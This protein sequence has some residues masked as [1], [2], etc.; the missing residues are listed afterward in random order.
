MG[1]ISKRAP[2][3]RR[4]ARAW[5]GAVIGSVLVAGILA[6]GADRWFYAVILYSVMIGFAG[7]VF[8]WVVV[9]EYSNDLQGSRL[10]LVAGVAASLVIFVL[11]QYFR[12]RLAVIDL[13]VRPGW[14]EY[15][16]DSARNTTLS[17]RIGRE[18]SDVGPL[19]AWGVRGLDL[20]FALWS[21]GYIAKEM[22]VHP[23]EVTAT[24]RR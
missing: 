1:V 3:Q 15:L 8:A 19:L 6:F 22:H 24:S 13:A 21:G 5:L 2:G 10:V 17:T 23:N 4:L 11:V 7:G 12:Y 20:G 16:V 9:E 18:G 14:W